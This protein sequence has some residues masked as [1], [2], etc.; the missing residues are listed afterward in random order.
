MPKSAKLPKISQDD[1]HLPKLPDVVKNFAKWPLLLKYVNEKLFNGARS[2]S[3]CLNKNWIKIRCGIYKHNG[4]YY[5]QGTKRSN[6]A[7]NWEN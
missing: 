1:Q 4:K 5:V 3:Y 2:F 6:N 7:E